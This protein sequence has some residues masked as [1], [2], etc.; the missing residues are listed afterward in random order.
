LCH[1]STGSKAST[2][3]Q[4]GLL[5]ELADIHAASKHCLLEG[6]TAIAAAGVLHTI[7]FN[8][9]VGQVKPVDVDSELFDITY[10]SRLLLHSHPTS[11]LQW[12]R[13]L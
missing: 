11:I 9:S 8:R 1:G 10:V 13:V 6:T 5:K 7:L 2:F 12:H 4:A 3:S